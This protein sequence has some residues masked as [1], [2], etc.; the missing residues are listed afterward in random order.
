MQEVAATLEPPRSG[1]D[2]AVV[3][4]PTGPPTTLC[5]IFFG[6]VPPPVPRFAI[7]LVCE[8]IFKL[9]LE[10]R[11]NSIPWGQTIRFR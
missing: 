10:R 4:I 7:T 1:N 2:A 3:E 9:Q 11:Q 8:N 6:F 5:D